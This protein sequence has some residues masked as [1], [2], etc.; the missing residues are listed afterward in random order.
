[1][2]IDRSPI[3]DELG[4]THHIEMP[5]LVSSVVVDFDVCNRLARLIASQQIPHDEE[6]SPLEGFSPREAGN[7][8]LLLVSICHQTSPRGRL[9]LEGSINGQ[10]KRGWDYLSAKLEI[11]AKKDR[12]LLQPLR[13]SAIKVS[14]ILEIFRDAALGDRLGEPERRTVLINDLGR[15]MLK[16][17]WRWFEDLYVLCDRRAASGNPNLFSLLSQFVAFSD[18]VRKKSSFVLALMQNSV[19][20]QYPDKDKVGPPVDYHEVRGHLRIGTVR[21]TSPDLRRKLMNP[22][23]VTGAEDV[24]IRSAV[25]EAIMLISDLSGLQNPSQLHYL[26]WNVFRTHCLRDRPLCHQPAPTLPDR[27]RPLAMFDDGERCPFSGVC[28]SA[29]ATHRYYEHVFET[30]YY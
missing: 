14:E 2:Q 29:S 3:I 19:H 26:F 22:A 16:H 10:P 8:Y 9:P 15:V 11:A 6:D 5:N 28:A 4:L 7:F 17:G 23:P 13:W 20:W 1:M 25:Y 30:D 18:P 12:S 27:Y 24:M 21:V